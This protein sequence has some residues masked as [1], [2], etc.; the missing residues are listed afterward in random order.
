LSDRLERG[1][2]KVHGETPAP[3]ADG[4]VLIEIH[5]RRNRVVLVPDVAFERS[6]IDEVGPARFDGIGA[7]TFDRS[8][9]VGFHCEQDSTR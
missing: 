7:L 2:A 9:L 5:V 3:D 1:R 6:Q 4:I 8:L